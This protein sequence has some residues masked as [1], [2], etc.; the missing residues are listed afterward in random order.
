MEELGD[1]YFKGHLQAL[2]TLFVQGMRDP[3]P[4]WPAYRPHVALSELSSCFPKKILPFL[5]GCRLPG[6]LFSMSGPSKNGGHFQMLFVLWSPDTDCGRWRVA[7]FVTAKSL[8][9]GL[10]SQRTVPWA[11]ALPIMPSGD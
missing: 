7:C 2:H 9:Q 3:A 8:R 6:L 5:S 4:R 1:E 10:Q 11:V